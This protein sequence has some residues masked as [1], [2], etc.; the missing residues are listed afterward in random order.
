MKTL[1]RVFQFLFLDYAFTSEVSCYNHSYLRR[2]KSY[3]K[4]KQIPPDWE[5]FPYYFCWE[6][7][8]KLV[9]VFCVVLFLGFIICL[10]RFSPDPS[11]AQ[12][13]LGFMLGVLIC[14]IIYAATFYPFDYAQTKDQHDKVIM[15]RFRSKK[16]VEKFERSRE[17]ILEFIQPILA[18]EQRRHEE[19]Q[20]EIYAKFE[21]D[22]RQAEIAKKQCRRKFQVLLEYVETTYKVSTP[23]P[24][25]V[26]NKFTIILP[27]VGKCGNTGYAFDLDERGLERLV[28]LIASMDAEMRRRSELRSMVN[29]ITPDPD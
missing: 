16:L 18:E 22:K 11:P 29:A 7:F 21:E 6:S 27:T 24:D 9:D 19:E 13:L 15:V 23:D 5:R 28:V 25:E 10:P 26:I 12:C 20:K 1:K 2:Y 8:F 14:V 3:C 17:E 4:E